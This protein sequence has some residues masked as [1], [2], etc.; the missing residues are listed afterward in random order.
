MRSEFEGIQ[1]FCRSLLQADFGFWQ[2][3]I[4][5]IMRFFKVSKCKTPYKTNHKYLKKKCHNFKILMYSTNSRITKYLKRQCLSKQNRVE[6]ANAKPP[7]KSKIVAK[8]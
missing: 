7:K 5:E 3:F 2:F 6:I 4:S 1:G 8:N